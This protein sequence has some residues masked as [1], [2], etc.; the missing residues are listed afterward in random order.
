MK[1]F[2]FVTASQSL[3]LQQI[4]TGNFMYKHENRLKIKLELA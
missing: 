3:T 2:V 1:K 4:Y